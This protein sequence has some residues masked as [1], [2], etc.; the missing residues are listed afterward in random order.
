MQ[1][2]LNWNWRQNA[3][4]NGIL[5]YHWK[6]LTRVVLWVLLMILAGQVIS[7]LLPL[8]TSADYTFS[9]V[10]TNLSVTLVTALISGILVAGRSTR[11]L[12]RFGTA[13]FPV[14][15]GN[16]LALLAGMV[17]LLLGTLLLSMLE[18]GIAIFLSNIMPERYIM[19]AQLGEAQGISTFQQTL[20]ETLQDLPSYLLYT[21]EWTAIFYLLGCC[22]RRNR[23]LTI[24]IVV[25]GP[26]LLMSL[27]F[28]PAVREAARVVEGGNETQIMVLGAQWMRYVMD[29]LTFIQ[30]QWLTIQL[31][32]ALVSLPLSYLCMRETPQP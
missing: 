18:G 5:R 22:F 32:G 17:A 14:W 13:R 29:I 16:V 11:F 23:G 20:Q 12:M 19:Q 4:L 8:F 31:V 2:T 15:L 30:N 1:Q 27:T 24:F 3:R 9:G 26:L 10:Y 28:I 6:T 25:G 7:L 21:L